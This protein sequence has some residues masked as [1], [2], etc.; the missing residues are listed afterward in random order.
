MPVSGETG[1]GEYSARRTAPV[2][3]GALP[4]PGKSGG[5]GGGIKST[6]PRRVTVRAGVVTAPVQ[7]PARCSR[8]EANLIRS[9]LL[10]WGENDPNKDTA[11]HIKWA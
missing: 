9:L 10:F 1:Q 2:A 6:E 4:R 8:A 11:F 3:P 7:G 5:G